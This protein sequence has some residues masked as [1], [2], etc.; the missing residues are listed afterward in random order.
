[1]SALKDTPRIQALMLTGHIPILSNGSRDVTEQPT[2]IDFQLLVQVPHW[3]LRHFV[4][5]KGLRIRCRKSSPPVHQF[6]EFRFHGDI[7]W[8]GDHYVPNGIN[9][10]IRNSRSTL[11]VFSTTRVDYHPTMLPLPRRNG[12]L[13]TEILDLGHDIPAHTA[14]AGV[15]ELMWLRANFSFGGRQFIIPV[16]LI[17]RMKNLVHLGIDAGY[18]YWDRDLDSWLKLFPNPSIPTDTTPS[19]STSLRRLTIIGYYSI[20]YPIQFVQKRLQS[21]F[22]DE[23]EVRLYPSLREYKDEV[24]SLKALSFFI[25]SSDLS[26]QA[27]K[28]IPR[29]CTISS[30]MIID[31]WFT[32]TTLVNQAHEQ[33]STSLASKLAPTQAFGQ[34][35]ELD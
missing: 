7:S 16:S 8:N 17:S 33:P 25:Y 28:L 19:F 21:V 34:E 32:M 22:E 9:W 5:G 11:R 15:K 6:V 30:S 2:D 20:K 1:M 12:L 27:L 35:V 13:S 31:D 23:V 26:P 14:L 18:Y 24:V 3:R 10:Y 29:E 4:L